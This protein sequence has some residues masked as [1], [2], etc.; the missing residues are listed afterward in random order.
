MYLPSERAVK[1]TMGTTSRVIQ[2][3]RA[4]HPEHADHPALAVAVGRGD[5]RRARQREQRFSLPMKIAWPRPRARCRAARRPTACSRGSS[6]SERNALDVVQRRLVEQVRLPAH[7][8]HR[9]RRAHP[10]STP[11]GPRSTRSR[12]A[13]SSAERPEAISACMARA[14]SPSVR[15]RGAR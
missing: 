10:R 3:R 4:D 13:V 12:L 2:P 14:A 11:R 5:D 1:S 9:R 7:D 6:I 8:Q 15:P